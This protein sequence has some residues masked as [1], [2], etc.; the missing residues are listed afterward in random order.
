MIKQNLVLKEKTL[1]LFFTRGIS[2]REWDKRGLLDREVA[3]YNNL[4]KSFKKIYFFTYGD[5]EDLDYREYLAENVIVI[6]NTTSLF[7]NKN[8]YSFMLPFIHRKVLKQVDILKTNQMDGSWAAVIAKKLFKKPLV[9]RMGYAWSIA[10]KKEKVK[11]FKK[12]I[13][14]LIE[15]IAY[16]NADAV[17]VTSQESLAHAGKNYCLKQKTLTSM[18]PNFV[19]INLFRP[20]ALQKKP[21]SLCFVGRLAKEKNLEAL[22][23]ALK[24]SSYLLDIIG[25]GEKENSLKFFAKENNINVNFLGVIPNR[26]LP[27]ALNRYEAFILPSFYEGMPKALLEAMACG[28]P[29][30]GTNVEGIREVI[31]DDENGLLCD[32][33]SNSIRKAIDKLFE[34]DDLR[35][36]L[37]EKAQETIINKFALEKVLKKE[38]D[39]Y[40]ELLD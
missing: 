40:T 28:L 11:Y 4:A 23:E 26:Q 17:I 14:K 2:L 7:R 27:E 21:N 6:P 34:D 3:L 9:V 29:V 20:M 24:D 12:W 25:S 39:M 22:L 8:L 30:I 16:L 19:D 35:E 31:V 32:I 33:T 37:G 1:A 36:K 13:V 15:K 18:I 38:L 10:Y 5:K